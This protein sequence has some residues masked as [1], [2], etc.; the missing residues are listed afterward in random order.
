MMKPSSVLIRGEHHL[1]K[2]IIIKKKK[3]SLVLF[4]CSQVEHTSNLTSRCTDLRRTQQEHLLKIFTF[5]VHSQM[6]RQVFWKGF[7]CVRLAMSEVRAPPS[8][9][10]GMGC[11]KPQ[12]LGLQ[13]RNHVCIRTARA[14]CWRE[15]LLCNAITSLLLKIRAWEMTVSRG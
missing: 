13:L 11:A 9:V 4:L 14:C 3:K 1:D 6:Q 2:I 5:Q 12:W 7:C 15:K 8:F 10:D